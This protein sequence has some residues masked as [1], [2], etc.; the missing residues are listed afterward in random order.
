MD[1]WKGKK[2][3]EAFIGKYLRDK[4]PN[5]ETTYLTERKRIRGKYQPLLQNDYGMANDC[6]L[7]ALTTVISGYLDK[8]PQG[9]YDVVEK[10]AKKYGYKGNGTNPLFIKNIFNNSLKEFGINKK[11]KTGYLKSFGYAFN[12][13]KSLIDKNIPIILSIFDDGH[14]CYNNHTVVIVGYVVYEVNKE[15]T[16]PMLLVYDNWNEKVGVVDYKM[17]SLIS[18]IN[19]LE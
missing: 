17:L 10:W 15:I 18:S 9:V 5:V 13:I 11:T 12:K 16:E 2:I 19:F 3:T 1:K 8:E 7:T 4:Y 6:T 14:Q